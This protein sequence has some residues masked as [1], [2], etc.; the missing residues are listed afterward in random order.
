M[1]PNLFC[2]YRSFNIG[3]TATLT[4]SVNRESDKLVIIHHNKVHNHA[5]SKEIYVQYPEQRRQLSEGIQQSTETMLKMGVKVKVNKVETAL[6]S[7]LS[8]ADTVVEV[9]R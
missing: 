6:G 2:F 5:I 9:K 8:V 7:H 4:A 1:H 3:C